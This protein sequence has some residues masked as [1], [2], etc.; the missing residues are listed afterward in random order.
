M[1]EGIDTGDYIA[2]KEVKVSPE[3]TGKTLYK[4]IEFAC[5]EI[6]KE[7]WPSIISGNFMQYNQINEEGSFHQKKDVN[8]IDHINLDKSYNARNLINILRARTFDNYES[9]YFKEDGKKY[10]IR[11]LIEREN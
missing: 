10:Y 11:V 8:L 9:A 2:R 4:K 7:T 5:I 3:D 1:D 6:F